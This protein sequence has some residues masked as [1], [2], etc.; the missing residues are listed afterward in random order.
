[1]S[2]SIP[3][4]NI[5]LLAY[6]T[7]V[8]DVMK[9]FFMIA[10]PDEMISALN[11][12]F[13]E[14]KDCDI[15]VTENEK[16]IGIIDHED[17]MI[18][19]SKTNNDWTVREKLTP[20][21]NIFYTDNILADIVNH[22]EHCGT[23]FPVLNRETNTVAGTISRCDIVMS[24]LKGT[25]DS[26][27]E[28]SEQTEEKDTPQFF[29]NIYADSSYLQLEYKIESKNFDKAGEASNQL[30]KTL[31][32]LN[33]PKNIIQRAAIIAYE[34]EM[35]IVIYSDGGQI[36]FNICP[37][38]IKMHAKDVGP[39]IENIDKAM[40]PGYSTAPDWVR[41]IGFGAGMGLQNINQYS[42]YMDL[43]STPGKGVNLITKVKA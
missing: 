6:K 17:L 3:F 18:L 37:E 21:K 30:K 23:R 42:D 25:L 31:S 13:Q 2:P 33:M 19:Q 9:V 26:T 14:N 11:N 39:G 20:T 4:S 27:T 22:F 16:V 35:N 7:K 38:Q 36:V 28:Y 15:I 24:L 5:D 12:R 41:E 1:M 29:K 43:K 34:T 40:Q 32:Y 10:Q 8:A